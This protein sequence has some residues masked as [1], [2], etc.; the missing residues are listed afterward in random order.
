MK[1]HEQEEN[2][3]SEKGYNAASVPVDPASTCD[4]VTQALWQRNLAWRHAEIREEDLIM[5]SESDVLI[6]SANILQPLQGGFRW[7]S[8][9]SVT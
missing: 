6:T 5:I 8:L 7:C 2:I 4:C 9:Q 3:F 1:S